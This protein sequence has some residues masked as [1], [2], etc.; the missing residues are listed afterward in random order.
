MAS[1]ARAGARSASAVDPSG[2]EREQADE[3]THS[4]ISR[5]RIGMAHV[6]KL[7]LRTYSL[8]PRSSIA[9]NLGCGAECCSTGRDRISQV[10]PY[11]IPSGQRG[12]EARSIALQDTH[13]P[14]R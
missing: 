10:G 8:G 7:K 6:R 3:S 1:P 13:L 11:R 2:F 12:S 4:K 9:E 14:N 5:N